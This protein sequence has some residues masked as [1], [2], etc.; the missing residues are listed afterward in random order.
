MTKKF[1]L[2]FFYEKSSVQPSFEHFI[3]IIYTF[4]TNINLMI[5]LQEKD[6]KKSL[7][8]KFCDNQN[9]NEIHLKAGVC[10]KGSEW[11]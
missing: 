4:I 11:K 1:K 7:E 2:F 8:W 6:K 10:L 3:S 9:K 5:L